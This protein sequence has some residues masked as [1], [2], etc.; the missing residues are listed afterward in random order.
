MEVVE[1]DAEGV[2]PF[3]VVDEAVEGL[4]GFG[5]V[6]L[7]EVDEVGAMGEDVGGLVEVEQDVELPNEEDGG[8]DV[9]SDGESKKDIKL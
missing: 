1:G 4:G 9:R 7:R 5:G 6:G 2:A 8:Q 3:E